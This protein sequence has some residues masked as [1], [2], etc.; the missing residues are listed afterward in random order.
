MAQLILMRWLTENGFLKAEDEH[1]LATGP[2]DPT[3]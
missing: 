3:A 1:T 2:D